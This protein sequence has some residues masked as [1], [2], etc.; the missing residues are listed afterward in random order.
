[1]T[2]EKNSEINKI[3]VSYLKT[4]DFG[5]NSWFHLTEQRQLKFV[6]VPMTGAIPTSVRVK[7]SF[8]KNG[9][10]VDIA[11]VYFESDILGFKATTIRIEETDFKLNENDQFTVGKS[12]FSNEWSV[13]PNMW[14]E[15]RMSLNNE[16]PPRE[17]TYYAAKEITSHTEKL[18][19]NFNPRE[20][21]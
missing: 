11:T 7:E 10:W 5:G 1:M 21:S 9:G 4:H 3:K 2:L 14:K 8:G 17:L 13:Q 6:S 18:L 12:I 15:I 16:K 20:L 19:T